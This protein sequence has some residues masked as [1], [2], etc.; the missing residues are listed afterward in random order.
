MESTPIDVDLESIA[1]SA[2]VTPTRSP[3][4]SAPCSEAGDEEDD[5]RATLNQTLAL[6]LGQLSV[7]LAE[8]RIEQ[9]DAKDLKTIAKAL[10]TFEK[11]A[12]DA[13]ETGDDKTL[14]GDKV[15]SEKR[16]SKVSRMKVWSCSPVA[17]VQV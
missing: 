11:A 13:A 14:E 12:L 6:A 4:P 10:R 1:S 3:A 8:A 16:D 5:A 15:Q 9:P 7:A 17:D 2:P